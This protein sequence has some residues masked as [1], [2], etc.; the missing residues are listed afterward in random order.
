[1]IWF[2]RLLFLPVLLLSLPYYGWRMIKRGGYR[3][4][5]H[6]R[7]GLI[8]RPP[9]KRKGV[10]RIWIQAVSVGEL[11]AIGPILEMLD[12]LG[13]IEIV[14]TTTT[15]TGYELARKAYASSLLKIG[16]FPIDFL[17]FSRSAWRRLDPDLAILMES[18]MWPEHLK[19]AAKRKVPVVLINGRLSDRS[20]RRYKKLPTVTRKLLRQVTRIMTA[21]DQDRQ[22]FEDLGALPENIICTGNLKFDVT[23]DP[24]LNP[25]ERDGLIEE[26]NLASNIKETRSPLRPPLIIL[27]SSTWPGEEAMLLS[28]LEEALHAG[29]NC[30][31]LL[32]P[33]HAERR[34][35]IKSLLE[36]Q[37]RHWHLRSTNSKPTKAVRIYVGDTTGELAYLSQIAD[38]AFVGKSLPPNE[39]GQTPIEAAALSIPIVYGP[40]MGNFRQICTSLENSG[41]ALRAENESDAK[42]LLL[43]LLQN[44]KKREKMAS[45]AREW[46]KKNRGA[47][48]RTVT[49]LQH[50][51]H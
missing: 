34:G 9:P 24:L 20:Y 47:T 6:H 45:A 31:L 39:G 5:F 41:A 46:H 2:Y 10:T 35:E 40:N 36:K 23:I 16:I 33:R 43:S 37:D 50:F 30:R 17:P 25:S 42:R 4:D 11:K 3:H 14:L 8:D 48:V 7:F 21:T 49:E 51:L 26:M 32:V 38:I 29:I 18:E 27:G 44:R 22:R 12:H 15:S 13:D 28:F 19:Q 1:M